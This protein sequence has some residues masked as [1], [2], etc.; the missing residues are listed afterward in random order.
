MIIKALKISD[1]LV[2]RV[3]VA[4]ADPLPPSTMEIKILGTEENY[5]RVCLP[6]FS[7]GGEDSAILV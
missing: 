4:V 7:V 3:A 5:L 2:V 6:E 1:P